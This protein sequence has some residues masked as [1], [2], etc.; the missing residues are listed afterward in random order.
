MQRG[1]KIQA[2]KLYREYTGAGLKESKDAIEAYERTFFSGPYSD[3]A[4]AATPF[5]ADEA[6]ILP[7]LYDLLR[8]GNKIEAIK[9]YRDHTNMGLQEAKDRVEQLEREMRQSGAGWPGHA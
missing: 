4:L 1:Q 9:V 6:D 8:T 3:S 7:E 5:Q 2:I